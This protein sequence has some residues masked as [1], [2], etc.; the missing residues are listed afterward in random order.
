MAPIAR[1]ALP[2]SPHALVQ[3]W[4]RQVQLA[5]FVGTLLDN[6]PESLIL[7]MWLANGTSVNIAFLAAVLSVMQ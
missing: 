2:R 4:A 7:G 1:T 3:V 6:I 5:A